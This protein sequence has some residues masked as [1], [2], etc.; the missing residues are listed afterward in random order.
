MNLK[1]YIYSGL[2]LAIAIVFASLVFL[3]KKSVNGE[4]P[5]II[6]F[7][8]DDMTPE[9]FNCLP[10]GRGKNLTPNLDR[11]AR[12]GV[13][14][15]NQR[16]VSPVCTPS[17][18]NS[19]T[20]NYASRAIN[21]EFL[22]D[23][24]KNEGQTVVNFNTHIV[25]GKNKTMGSYFQEL[26]Y[27][28]GFVGKNHVVESLS[29][30]NDDD[31]PDLYVDP[32]DPKVKVGLEHRH[33]LLQEDIKKCGFDFA[34]NLYHNNP[35]WLG[36][37]ALNAQN[38]DWIAQGGLRFIETYKDEPFLMYFA[39][40]L[41]HDPLNPENS[42]DADPRITAKGFLDKPLNVLPA[43][44]TLKSR[45]KEAGL[46]GKKVTNLL[47]L[48]DALGAL[49]N[50]LEETG[51]IDNTII[52]FFTDHGQHNKGTLYEGGIHSQS[53]V[54]RSSGF[55]C[56]QT[57][58]AKVS[59]IDFLPTLLDF[60]GYESP[61]AICDGRSFKAALEDGDYLE[62][63]SMYHELGYARAVVKGKFKFLKL[64]YPEFAQNA[65]LEERTKMLDDYNELRRSFGGQAINLDP[66][67]PYGHLELYPG[68]GGAEKNT[69]GKKP[70]FFEAEQLYDLE[71]D[72]D[73]NV[74]LANDPEFAEKLI[75]MR[76]ELK[77]YLD[78]LPGQFVKE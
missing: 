54:W 9:M 11:L 45:I 1:K 35:S 61:D 73:E 57:C 37:K 48:D 36:V 38:M 46:E 76:N 16:V 75:E 55:E 18:Y 15:A 42:Y 68:G 39:T 77:T 59:N 43:R 13:F 10:E 78:K 47:W 51:T 31:K 21:A 32:N 33:H 5:N 40:T 34:D 74:N 23:T 2:G 6:F 72:P 63:E 67:L 27:K 30:I 64:N 66:T 19:L 4:Q 22:E 60:A 20:G 65:T 70:A 69:F 26:G 28:T 25:P 44:E 62:R 50:K 52:L 49:L 41:P 8:A 56:G 58:D 3:P 24:E 17:R 14:M 53:I 29:Q 71:A 7:I 12:E